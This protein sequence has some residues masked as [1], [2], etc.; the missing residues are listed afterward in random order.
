MT[1][2]RVLHV[3]GAMNRGGAETWLVHML[4][5]VDREEV[6]MDFLVHTDRPAAY[7]D[8]IIGLGGRIF[9][10]PFHRNPNAYRRRFLEIVQ[11]AGPFHVLHSHVHHF[12]G[13]VLWLG[14]RAGI[15]ILISHSHNDTSSLQ[16]NIPRTAYLSAM[17]RLISANATHLLAASSVAA[18]DLFGHRWRQDPRAQVVFC[19]IDL[20]PFRSPLDS[21]EVRTDFGFRASDIVFGHVGR[22]DHQK[23]HRLL[24]E[25]AADILKQEPR[26]RF[27]LAG[28]GPL[29]IAME[30]HA[31]LLG[32]REAVIFA[33]VRTDVPRLMRGAM[34]ALIFPSHYEGLPLALM[35]AQAAG[36]HCLISDSIAHE[37]AVNPTLIRR[38]ALSAGPTEWARAANQLVATPRCGPDTALAAIE[39]SPFDVSQSVR[40]MTSLYL[41]DTASCKP[42]NLAYV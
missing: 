21:E 26:A 10:C 11:D 16:T 6:R 42:G 32:V 24:I 29:R 36:L 5:H 12:S 4:R 8:Q 2:V 31:R 38:L 40:T 22:F 30:R 33:G 27:L 3:L 28:D 9:R 37:T 17:R 39:R 7:D 1:P 41:S 35:E 25:I 14:R 15:P 18:I 20:Q 19:G 23:N 34:D 13:Y